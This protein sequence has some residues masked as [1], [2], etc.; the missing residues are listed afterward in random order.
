MHKLLLSILFLFIYSQ[1]AFAESY[2][3]VGGVVGDDWIENQ[4]PTQ[5]ALV[6]GI[7]EYQ[8]EELMTLG[9][10]VNDAKLLSSALRKAGVNLPNARILLDKQATRIAFVR[11]WKN[12]VNE[13][14]P[15][16]ILIVTFAGH[17][18]QEKDMAPLGEP[19][20]KDETLIFHDFKI[21][22]Q[23]RSSPQ[24]RI[25]DDELFGLF[26]QAI[27]YK[28]LFIADSCHSSGMLR[29]SS[30]KPV[31]KSRSG[32]YSKIQVNAP[33]AFPKLP[34]SREG[35][36]H[37]HVSFITAVNNDHL[38]VNETILDDKF[39]GALSWYFAQAISG[40][41]DGNKNGRLERDELDRFLTENIQIHT[42][43]NQTPKV[44]PY[45][46]KVSAFYLPQRVDYPTIEP[47]RS[48]A[49]VVQ[50]GRAPRGLKHIRLVDSLKT[51]D[52]VFEIK[53]RQAVVFNQSGDK[54]TTI[55]R[56]S[57][58]EWQRL[59]NKQRLLKHLVTEFNM[60]L[61]PIKINLKEGNGLHKKGKY[62]HFSIGSSKE[63]L[64]AL[65][66][67]GLGAK[68]ELQLLYP[69]REYGDP[70]KV[71][72][73]P[74]NLPPMTAGSGGEDLIVV[75]C[76]SPAK[77]LQRLLARVE[78]ELPEP[79]EFWQ[80]LNGSRRMVKCQVGQYAVFGE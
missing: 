76:R 24:G 72:R 5:H 32:G 16:D 47:S 54:L 8:S 78:P 3:G 65:T 80:S 73:F 13:A 21:N 30:R 14:K 58:P 70:A 36:P 1:T 15:G 50:N 43:H 37:P 49:I 25:T 17:G 18:G 62:L 19:D 33:P 60:R 64:K 55:S 10:A 29:S 41:A 77:N 66:L 69:I 74:Y 68:G 2:R 11:A 31:G 51:F 48:I 12:M 44:L 27:D 9:G 4:Q 38:R 61:S 28:I 23:R 63:N 40:K 46:N 53:G 45:S 20:K 35:K 42:H 67:F 34:K 22:K 52:L 79:K 75:L 6:V 71:H 56:S 39:H 7:D 57:K 59:I 26:E